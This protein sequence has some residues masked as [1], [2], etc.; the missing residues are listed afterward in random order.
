MS[1]P[2]D[3]GIPR[4]QQ[5]SSSALTVPLD[6]RKRTK[7]LPRIRRA[8]GRLLTSFPNAATY[9]QF[10]MK[11]DVASSQT[12]PPVGTPGTAVCEMRR[13]VAG[14]TPSTDVCDEHYQALPRRR[15]HVGLAQQP[16][17]DFN[18]N[19]PVRSTLVWRDPF[20]KGDCVL[21]AVKRVSVLGMHAD[22]LFQP[23]PDHTISP[24]VPATLTPFAVWF[25][26][27]DFVHGP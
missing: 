2:R 24:N 17:P 21:R 13:M 22:F 20:E 4:W 23:F 26:F 11:Q 12:F 15:P 25:D 5:R 7:S 18:L 19:R 27:V 6:C 1:S 8:S 14:A 3:S 10:L 16:S 9:Q